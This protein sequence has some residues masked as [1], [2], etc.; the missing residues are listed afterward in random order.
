MRHAEARRTTVASPSPRPVPC[1]CHP[2]RRTRAR[3]SLCQCFSRGPATQQQKATS[4]ESPIAL[5]L[6]TEIVRPFVTFPSLSNSAC[7]SIGAYTVHNTTEKPSGPWVLIIS[8]VQPAFRSCQ[9][10][11]GNLDAILFL[12]LPA[13]FLLLFAR[14][15]SN[16][17]S[18]LPVPMGTRNKCLLLGPL[19][20][21][22]NR[23]T[24]HRQHQSRRSPSLA[25]V[26][27]HMLYSY[28]N[29]LHV[30]AG[31]GNPRDDRD[32]QRQL[33]LSPPLRKRVSSTMSSTPAASMTTRSRTSQS[34]S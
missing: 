2:K 1:Q 21:A 13:I 34:E 28:S 11:K 10:N 12:R 15:P 29:C 16:A 20:E 14:N 23:R 6:P 22:C 17:P 24:A 30:W 31:V 3:R 7:C 26:Y 9:P 27:I 32:G 5:G 19:H 4:H 33:D 25:Y 18:Q 8:S